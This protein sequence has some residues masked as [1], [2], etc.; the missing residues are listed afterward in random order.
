MMAELVSQE[1][2]EQAYVSSVTEGLRSDVAKFWPVSVTPNP[3]VV[4]PLLFA[5]KAENTGESNENM[6]IFVLTID[7]MVTAAVIE[8]VGPPTADRHLMTVELYQ[9]ALAQEVDPTCIDGVRFDMA[10]LRPETVRVEPPVLGEF[11]GLPSVTTGA[12]K[13]TIF[14]TVPTVALTVKETAIARP[15]ETG[16]RHDR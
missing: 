14:S 10:K 3:P 6:A 11:D 13:V 12:S 15:K 8:T 1:V 2:V 9:L 16:P 4:G 7:E 5:K